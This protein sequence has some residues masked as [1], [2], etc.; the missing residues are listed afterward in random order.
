LYVESQTSDPAAG[1]SH[2]HYNIVHG[3]FYLT[4]FSSIR[5]VVF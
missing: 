5:L 1:A 2:N 3:A 4:S